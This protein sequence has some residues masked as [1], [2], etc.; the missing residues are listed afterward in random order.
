MT[1]EHGAYLLAGLHISWCLAVSHAWPTLD[2]PF[3]LDMGNNISL[4]HV[5]L[6]HAQSSE[7]NLT[8]IKLG[9]SCFETARV[10]LRHRVVLESCRVVP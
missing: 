1:H 2:K 9:K 6:S 3:W 7:C 5:V 4:S 10:V 8:A